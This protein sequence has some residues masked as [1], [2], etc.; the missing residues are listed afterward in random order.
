MVSAGAYA[1]RDRPWSVAAVFDKRVS[2][3]AIYDDAIAIR[4]PTE[5]EA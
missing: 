5:P 2:A 4:V 1:L 3:R